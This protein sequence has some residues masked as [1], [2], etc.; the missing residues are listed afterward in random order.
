MDVSEAVWIKDGLQNEIS[1]PLGSWH[2]LIRVKHERRE[3]W[4]REPSGNTEPAT[5]APSAR[6]ED[7]S[8]ATIPRVP[9]IINEP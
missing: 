3:G 2:R 1:M 4:N 9:V 5:K 7:C 8:Q 6:N